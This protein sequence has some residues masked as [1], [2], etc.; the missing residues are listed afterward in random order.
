MC[1]DCCH[2]YCSDYVKPCHSHNYKGD[3]GDKG[4]K[5]CKGDIG[6]IGISGPTGDTGSK[7]DAGSKGDTGPKGVASGFLFVSTKS[8]QEFPGDDEVSF[9]IQTVLDGWSDVSDN[10]IFSPDTGGLYLVTY[11]L[12]IDG[13]DGTADTRLEIDNVTVEGSKISQVIP[14]LTT[15]SYSFTSNTFM[16]FIGAG[17]EVKLIH[18]GLPLYTPSGTSTIASLSITKIKDITVA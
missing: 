17:S 18:N 14:D 9:E 6:P 4:C 2:K 7:G 16:V 13:N 12:S 8:E 11:N 15:T 1:D 5:G 10:K 3:K